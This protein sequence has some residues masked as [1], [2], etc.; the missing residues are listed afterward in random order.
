MWLILVQLIPPSV[1]QC[2][3]G[4]TEISGTW[5]HKRVMQIKKQ[6]DARS[7][8][9]TK[10]DGAK[11]VDV[12]TRDEMLVLLQWMANSTDAI[13]EIVKINNSPS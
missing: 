2:A 8:C 13:F 7:I 11:L 6:E 3:A 4:F 9:P 12:E 5:C 10:G 1:C